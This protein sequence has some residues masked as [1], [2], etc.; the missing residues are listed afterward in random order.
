M[1]PTTTSPSIDDLEGRLID[2][3]DATAE[4]ERALGAASLDGKGEAE[5]QA[6]ADEARAEERRLSMSIE[7][8]GRREESA[9]AKAAKEAA[10]AE[11]IAIYSWAR[12]YLPLVAAVLR[13]HEAYVQA[14]HKLRALTPPRRASVLLHTGSEKV[15]V[16]GI[17]TRRTL[18]ET[19][20]DFPL[21]NG[22]PPPPRGELKTAPPF[23]V[24]IERCEELVARANEVIAAEERGE[25]ESVVVTGQHREEERRARRAAAKELAKKEAE[26]KQAEK[27]RQAEA[28]REREEQEAAAVRERDERRFEAIASGAGE[29]VG[30]DETE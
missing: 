3:R 25:A 13:S 24:S 22:T 27:Q 20:L 16:D 9:E 6:V 19:E 8:L 23:R 28:D 14:Q 10:R 21:M 7:E 15:T 18:D 2:A 29:L 11:R 12:D 26:E 5:A 17:T 4:A 1:N 30:E